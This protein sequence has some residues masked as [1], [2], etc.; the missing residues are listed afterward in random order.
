MK[1]DGPAFKINARTILNLANS[2]NPETQYD[3]IQIRE[4]V[5]ARSNEVTPEADRRIKDMGRMILFKQESSEVGFIGMRS[6][7][8]IY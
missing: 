4:A 7:P 2:F 6:G 1:L 3:K 8:N 5:Y